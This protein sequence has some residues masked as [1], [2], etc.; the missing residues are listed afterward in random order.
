MGKTGILYIIPLLFGYAG[1]ERHLLA[2]TSSLDRSRFTPHVAC[3]RSSSKV[4]QDFQEAGVPCTTFEMTRIYGIDALKNALK[5]RR[6]I[7]ENN[8]SI[9]QTFHPKADLYC[10]LVGKLSSVPLIIS[11][12]RD[13]GYNRSNIVV[14]KFINRF[15]DWIIAPSDIVREFTMRQEKVPESKFRIIY[16]GV[17]TDHY[18]PLENKKDMRL[19]LGLPEK[20]TIVVNVSNLY[21]IKG[22]DLF[23]RA[24]RSVADVISDTVF[25]IIGDGRE[26]QNLLDL[27]AELGMGDRIIFTGNIANVVEYLGSADLYV[28]SSLSEGFSNSILEAMAMG[29]PVVAT[30][31]GGN[32]EAVTNGVTGFLVEKGHVTDIAEKIISILR[33][34][35]LGSSLGRCGRRVTEEKFSLKKMIREYEG[36]YSELIHGSR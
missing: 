18:K 3:F 35:E 2:L 1:T 19:K 5:I 29:L 12:R 15:V 30:D 13:L 34:P 9:L 32:P 31:V 22:V 28:C 4:I 11:S 27:T 25:V 21:K 7:M 24:A 23:I 10:P 33:D 14:Q 16:N 36:L 8:I 6:Y 26:K 17:D 20:G